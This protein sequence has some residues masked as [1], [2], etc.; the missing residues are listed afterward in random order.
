MERREEIEKKQ[1]ESKIES[2][3]AE[4]KE[5][6]N[7]NTSTRK[8]NTGKGVEC[9]EKKFGL[10]TYETQFVTRTGEKNKYFMHDM[11]KLAVDVTFTQITAKKGINNHV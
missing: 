1:D 6:G 3:D 7:T 2:G 10:K 11:K 8:S 9:L 5:R 4:T